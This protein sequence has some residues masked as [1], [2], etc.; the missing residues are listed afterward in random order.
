[1]VL[2]LMGHRSTGH[3]KAQAHIVVYRKAIAFS[4]VV[5]IE[6]PSMLLA[7][8]FHKLRGLWDADAGVA[9]NDALEIGMARGDMT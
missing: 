2:A 5:L 7:G 3:P 8:I 9:M 1:M 6:G 4:G